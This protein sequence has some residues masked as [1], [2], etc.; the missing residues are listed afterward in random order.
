MNIV[1]K[2]KPKMGDEI[3]PEHVSPVNEPKFLTQNKL[4]CRSF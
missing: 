1:R 4:Q 2:L 3:M